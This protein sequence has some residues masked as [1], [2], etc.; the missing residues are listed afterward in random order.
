MRESAAK[1][2][3]VSPCRADL[4]RAADESRFAS[5]PL[6]LSRTCLAYIGR[7]DD[8]DLLLCPR[9]PALIMWCVTKSDVQRPGRL[10]PSCGGLEAYNSADEYR[11][12]RRSQRQALSF[13]SADDKVRRRKD[14]RGPGLKGYFPNSA[15]GPALS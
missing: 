4:V 15:F 10:T 7:F 11:L 1:P 12:G 9:H 14:H 5:H 6:C 3:A 2:E 13:F 8:L